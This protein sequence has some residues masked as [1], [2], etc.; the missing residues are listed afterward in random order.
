MN[1]ILKNKN[2]LI[3]GSTEGI[4]LAI[5]KSYA[6]EGANVG[7]IARNE[8][9]LKRVK[10]ELSSLG[11]EVYTF[12]A[13]LSLPSVIQP[14][15]E[16]IIKQMSG[17][18]ILVNNAG[19]GRFVPFQETNEE[20][21]DLHLNLNIKVPY[22]LTQAIYPSLKKRK[23]NIIN[24]SSYFSHRML[25]GR[26]TTAYSLT[27]G[28]LDSFTKSLAFESGKEGVRVNAIAPGS[29]TTPQ[30]LHNIE[31]LTIEGKKQFRDM[32]ETIYPLRKIGEAEDVAQAAVFLASEQA[33]WITGTI[34]PVDGGLTTN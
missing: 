13:D 15:T 27:K 9:K 34:L 12:S 3:T 25:P 20:L 17:I 8:E 24:I 33:K 10:E 11:V 21:L 4:G 29:I 1:D 16:Q 6:R 18:D 31:Q 30:L 19:I 23:G 26:N 2:A 14:L 22:L 32:I 5:A 28:A 7:L